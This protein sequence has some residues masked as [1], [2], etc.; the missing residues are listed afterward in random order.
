MS[1]DAVE[2]FRQAIANDPDDDAARRAF[3]AWLEQNDQADRAQWIRLSCELADMTAAC[4]RADMADRLAL[5]RRVSEAFRRCRPD[6]WGYVSGVVQNNQRGMFRLEPGSQTAIVRLGKVPWLADALAEGWLEGISLL[7]DDT[8]VRAV[9]AWKG[10][11][12]DAPLFVRLNP[13]ISNAGLERH[14]AMPQLRG[15][16]IRAYALQNEAVQTLGTNTA[17]RELCISLRRID[18]DVMTTALEQIA[19]MTRLRR[20]ELIGSNGWPRILR[21]DDSDIWRLRHMTGLHRLTLLD[22]PHITDAGMAQLQRALP[23]L[24]IHDLRD[25]RESYM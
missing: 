6:W 21:P 2:A 13:S 5:A 20:F 24:R 4:P 14:L 10:P 11:A 7:S 17:L 3:A 15:L 23:S 22:C 1:D 16:S 19:Q 25:R 9:C 8:I 12:R 18:S